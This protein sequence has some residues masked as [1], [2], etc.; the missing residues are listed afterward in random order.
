MSAHTK[1]DSRVLMPPGTMTDHERRQA[2]AKFRSLRGRGGVEVG[3]R[4]YGP[5]L[6][7]EA[8]HEHEPDERGEGGATS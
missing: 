5:A 4:A 7:A 2:A 6:T 1:P 8:V 3:W